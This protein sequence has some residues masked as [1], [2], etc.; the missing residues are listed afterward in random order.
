MVIN[1]AIFVRVDEVSL[2]DLRKTIQ[3]LFTNEFASPLAKLHEE[4]L[5]DFIA[6]VQREVEALELFDEGLAVGT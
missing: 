1:S 2:L 5:D 6:L 4:L 3:E